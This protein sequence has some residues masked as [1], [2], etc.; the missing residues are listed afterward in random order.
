MI[1]LFLMG[2]AACYDSQQLLLH[3]G[4]QMLEAGLGH[5]LH[6]ITQPD[7]QDAY[8]IYPMVFTLLIFLYLIIHF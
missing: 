3:V 2:A 4:V 7:P 6:H 1:C 5:M 8:N